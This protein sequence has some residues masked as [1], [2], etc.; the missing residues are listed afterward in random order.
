[1]DALGLQSH[2]KSYATDSISKRLDIMAGND[3]ETRLW[4]TEFDIE[5]V[6][7]TK[8]AADL[9]DFLRTVYAH[10]NVDA[11]ILWTWLREVDRPWN[12][13]RFNRALFESNLDF[14]DPVVEK[15]DVCDEFNVLCNYPLN[16]NLAGETY[17]NLVKLGC[18]DV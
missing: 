9:E 10:P 11:I 2:I 1:M 3:L 17:L 15:P 4:I 14:G 5:E 12:D 6:D 13:V 18:Q 16:M 8:R 7:V